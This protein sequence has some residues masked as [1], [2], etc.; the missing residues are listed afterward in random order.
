MNLQEYLGANTGAADDM[1]TRVDEAAYGKAPDGAP[2]TLSYGEYLAKRRQAQTEDFRR[3]TL[4]DA[5]D[6]FLAA[7]GTSHAAA[8][9]LVDPRIQQQRQA[10]ESAYWAKQDELRRGIEA[11]RQAERAAQDKRFSAASKAYGERTRAQEAG[12]SAYGSTGSTPG[13]DEATRGYFEARYG[14]LGDARRGSRYRLAAG[15]GG[16]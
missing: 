2:P 7:N 11:N 9:R 10:E 13:Q 8:P 16:K 14:S 1:A 6:A 3:A 15:K 5:G 4:G 12:L